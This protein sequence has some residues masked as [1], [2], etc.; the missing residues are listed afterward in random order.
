MSATFSRHEA[1]AIAR[2]IAKAWPRWRLTR[3]DSATVLREF[4]SSPG[5]L[6]RHGLV[7]DSLGLAGLTPLRVKM[8]T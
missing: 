1:L 7:G 5:A 2:V 8:A 6:R 3:V 4:L